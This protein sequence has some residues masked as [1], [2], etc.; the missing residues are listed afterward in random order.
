MKNYFLHTLAILLIA[1]GTVS[2]QDYTSLIK[3]RLLSTKTSDGMTPQDLAELTIYNQSTNKR[4]GVEHV[5]AVQKH[6]GI[7][8]FNANV[9]VAF[10]GDKIVHVGDNLQM[11]M[12][13]RVKNTSPVLTP[14]Q[15][16]TKAASLLGVG[17]A[18]FSILEKT[19]SQKVILNDG[20]VSLHDVAVK[21]VYEVTDTNELRLAWDLSIHTIKEPHFYSVRIDAMNGEMLSQFDLAVSCT[22]G[23]HAPSNRIITSSVKNKNQSD[24]GF[25]EEAAN[26][27]LNGAQYNV[28]PIP[29]ESPVHGTNQL[30]VDPHDLTASPFG[31]H[32]TDGVEGAEFTIS[33]G[34]NVWAREDLEGDDDETIGQSP[35][36]GEDLNFNFQYDFNSVPVNMVEASTTNLFYVTNIVHDIMYQ[37]GFDEESGNFQQ[38]NYNGLGAGNDAV[39][40]ESQD[41]PTFGNATFS[42]PPDGLEPRLQMGIW[43]GDIVTELLT[44]TNSSL[45]GSYVG[46]PAQ[47]GES[48]PPEDT[49]T[50]FTGE[51]VLLVDDDSVVGGEPHD[52]CDPIVNAAE[53][54]G[55]VAVIRRNVCQF[56][57]K[58]LAAESAGAAAVI[59][60]NNDPEQD[61]FPMAFGAVGDQV[62]IPSIMVGEVDGEAIIAALQAGESIN[63]SIVDKP[64]TFDFDSALDNLV[65]VHEYAHG[66]SA[67]LILGPGNTFC[68]TNAES[69][70]EGWSD[71][72]GLMLTMTE[73]DTAEE[74]RGIGTY[75]TRDAT[76]NG[77]RVRPY[78]TDFSIND[79]TYGDTNDEE[80][81]PVPHGIGTVWATMLW[82]M[83]W[84]LIDEYGFDADLYNGVAGNNISLQLVTDGLKLAPCFPGF[85]EGRD[86]ILAA[87]E[88]NTMIPEEDK[89]AI[90]C[91]IWGVFAQRGLGEGANQGNSLS[92][93]DNVE[94][95]EAPIFDDATGTCPV[96]ILNTEEF[97]ENNF[98]VFPNPSN[99][100]V[101]LNMN[102]SLGNGQIKIVDL[103][104]RIVFSQD[105]LLE[106]TIS[107]NA[108]GLSTGVYLLQVSNQD[109]SETTKLIIK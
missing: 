59:V 35:D 96:Q 42:T 49:T 32:D 95:F 44:I 97:V 56:S 41:R 66:I 55:N 20:G 103:N 33:R 67:R 10:Q 47:F 106:G 107:I 29:V 3:N 2:A 21:L 90:T 14:M 68:L 84:F 74:P 99:G 8:V 57:F 50:P 34:N 98:S 54:T 102:T 9:A 15:A 46:I 48:F 81:I 58:V 38:T 75:G 45:Q 72:Y 94:D 70:D 23:D 83:T 93:T 43:D 87:V 78:T 89:E 69:M 73:D 7:E 26:V 109:V 53:L 1:M 36:G 37:Y 105:S 104:G 65:V 79:L 85:V 12:A 91:G 62:T 101:R 22:F 60:V 86:A 31:W 24:F 28:F 17:V 77:I 100:Q 40:A 4:S 5:Y 19:S 39:V 80:N 13:S 82:D 51:L 71:Y 88:I 76:G 6:N 25:K 108:T 11:G 18:N 61:P 27:A 63:A 92:R 52:A 64:V 16:A 30:V